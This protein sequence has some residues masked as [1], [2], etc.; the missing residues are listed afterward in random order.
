MSRSQRK[1]ASEGTE[2]SQSG[3]CHN[4]GVS[5]M[6]NTSSLDQDRAPRPDSQPNNEIS[7]SFGDI[8]SQ[9]EQTDKHRAEEGGRGLEGVVI[10][11]SAD[12][13][14]LDIGFKTEGMIRSEER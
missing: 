12:S 10:A 8:L 11:I 6:A 4:E 2:V 14:F 13:V 3:L 7:E 9:Y 1:R 5:L